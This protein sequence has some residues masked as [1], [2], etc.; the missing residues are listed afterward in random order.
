MG[1]IQFFSLVCDL[2]YKRF[3]IKN[4][5]ELD[6]KDGSHRRCAVWYYHSSVLLIGW[7]VFCIFPTTALQSS[8]I[9]IH[10]SNLRLNCRIDLHRTVNVPPLSGGSREGDRVQLFELAL[11]PLANNRS[12]QEW[13]HNRSPQATMWY[14]H[15]ACGLASQVS[16]MTC[17]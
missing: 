12:K 1:R 4:P 17:F 10:A 2:F 11:T 8:R 16:W 7:I 5:V 15:H 14:T 3:S 9:R 6:T 13:C